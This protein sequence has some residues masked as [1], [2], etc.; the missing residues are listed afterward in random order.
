MPLKPFDVWMCTHNSEKLLP[1][2]L[3]Q[4]SR[5]IPIINKKFIVDD[6]ST[7]STKAVAKSLGWQVFNSKK[8]GLHNARDYAFSLV[9]TEYCA[10]FE[11]DIYL[12][13]NWYPTIPN[14]VQS[15][16][17]DVAQGIRVRD[18][19]GFREADIYDYNHRFIPSEDNTFYKMG[20]NFQNI[21]RYYIE[22]NV[23]SRHL[24]GNIS[25]CLR[26]DYF[27]YRELNN[28]GVFSLFKCLA[29]SPFLSI[30]VFKETKG[31]LVLFAYPMERLLIFNGGL[32]GKMKRGNQKI[33]K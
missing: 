15:G 12:A 17:Y 2:V 28:A 5:V 13:D 20:T 14:L 9:E 33:V 6:F 19:G 1:I 11:H 26:H 22:K 23:C 8:R 4:I 29:K 24:R 16:K 7:D 18:I 27:I 32:M 30:K 3:P 31:G 21:E 10:N 25:N